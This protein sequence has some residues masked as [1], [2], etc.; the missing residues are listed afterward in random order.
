MDLSI[1]LHGVVGAEVFSRGMLRT[2]VLHLGWKVA[3]LSG[4]RTGTLA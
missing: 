1:M 3:V 4:E 2:G